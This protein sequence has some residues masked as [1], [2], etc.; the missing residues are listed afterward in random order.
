[1]FMLLTGEEIEVT[2]AQ[3]SSRGL[4]RPVEDYAA[5]L[6]RSESGVLGALEFGNMFPYAGPDRVAADGGLRLS[7][8]DGFLAFERGGLRLVTADGEENIEFQR[9]DEPP[10]FTMLRDTLDNWQQ[11]EAPVTSVD[12]CYRAARLIDRAYALA[13]QS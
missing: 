5:V 3:I 4:G 1:M 13:G 9:P 2:G 12:D 10:A 11:G 7:G 6:L 8:R